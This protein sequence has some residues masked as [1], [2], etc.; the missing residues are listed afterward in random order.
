M[1]ICLPIS[2]VKSSVISHYSAYAYAPYLLMSP[3]SGL[4]TNDLRCLTVQSIV[5]YHT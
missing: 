1:R 2:G 5:F 3:T 4:S